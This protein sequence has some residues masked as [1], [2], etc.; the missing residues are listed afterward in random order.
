MR[1]TSAQTS[2]FVAASCLAANAMPT[3]APAKDKLQALV[4]RGKVNSQENSC[5]GCP[6]SVRDLLKRTYTDIKVTF[7]G[8]DEATKINA[9]TLAG[10]DIFAQPGGDGRQS[11]ILTPDVMF[12]HANGCPGTDLDD[13]WDEAK[14]YAPA[15]R[16]FVSNGGHYLGFCLGAYLAGP[17]PGFGLL[18]KGDKAVREIKQRNAQI[19]N[20]ND[21]VIQVDWTFSTGDKAGKTEN[22]R[23][24][25]FQD[26]PAFKL[27]NGS[28]AEVLGRYSKNGDVAAML[29]AYG[30]GWVANIGPHPEADQYWCKYTNSRLYEDM[31]KAAK[32]T[33]L[34]DD[35]AEIKNPE[36]IKFDI[37]MDFV[38]AA[39]EAG[40]Q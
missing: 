10:V 31:H 27:A 12:I 36:G 32:L 37:G 26:G 4:Y 21:T 39:L 28:P 6:E 40:D 17:S 33:Q 2:A 34:A 11:E 35:D 15:M 13:A 30:Q 22:G 20:T 23:W 1:P 3:S 7:A 24:L 8:P 16:D 25:Y 29:N 5:E 38:K 9:Q 14:A 18:P 19:K